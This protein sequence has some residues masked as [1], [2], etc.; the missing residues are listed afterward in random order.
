[1]RNVAE[2]G[3]DILKDMLAKVAQQPEDTRQPFYKN[4]YMTILQHV[5]AVVADSNQVQVAGLTYFAEIMCQLFQALEMSIKVPLN[6]ANPSQSNIDFVFDS[7][8]AIFLEHFNHLSKDQVR[9]IIKGFVSFNT[10]VTAMKNHIR[11]FLVQLKEQSGDDPSDL[12]LEDREKEIQAA[13]EK[14]MAIPGMMNPNDIEEDD[15]R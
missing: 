10:N 2:M 15:M 1:M 5:L 13:Q 4:F 9:I 8:S 14:K 7:I 6:D 3:L 12:F 11:D